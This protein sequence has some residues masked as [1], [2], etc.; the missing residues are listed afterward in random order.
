MMRIPTVGEFMEGFERVTVAATTAILLAVVVLAVV[1][2]GWVVAH[3]AVTGPFLIDAREGGEIGSSFLLLALAVELVGSVRAFA[4]DGS[5]PVP[6]ILKIAL[7]A[8]ARRAF[9]PGVLDGSAGLGLA[10]LIAAIVGGLLVE[11]R[12]APRGSAT[13]GDPMDPPRLPF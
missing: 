5:V 6:S 9:D 4:R 2:L 7:L 12:W 10:A 8:V 13:R 1:Q 11:R 3:A